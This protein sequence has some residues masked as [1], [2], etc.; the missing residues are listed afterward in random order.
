[1]R[2]SKRRSA[3]AQL[4]AHLHNP[5]AKLVKLALG[6]PPQLTAFLSVVAGLFG[7]S[8]R[9]V[10]DAVQAFVDGRSAGLWSRPPRFNGTM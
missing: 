4:V 6:F 1:M 9:D 7:H 8:R 2:A 5:G 3:C 10:L